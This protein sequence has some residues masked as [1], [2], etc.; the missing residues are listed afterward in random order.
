MKSYC[1]IFILCHVVYFSFGQVNH[2]RAFQLALQRDN[3]GKEYS[4]SQTKVENHDSL[5]LVYPGKITTA[6]GRILKI[7]TSRWYWGLAPRATTR[8]IIFNDE[9]QYL[10]DYHLTMTYEVPDKIEKTSLVFVIDKGK[11]S[12][13]KPTT[14]V[15]FKRGIPRQFFVET[16]DS[17]AGDVFVFA[18]N[19]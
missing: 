19:L 9:N 18:Q 4:F 2:Q 16:E 5:V 11:E 17:G 8:I 7:L 1:L 12:T 10:G 15:N 3:I 6:N 13:Y 14:K